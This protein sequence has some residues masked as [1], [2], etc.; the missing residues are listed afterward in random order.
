QPVII[1]FFADW[2][3]PC[4]EMEHVTYRDPQIIEASRSFIMVKVDV[5]HVRST[6]AQKLIKE[7]DVSGI[8][9]LIFLDSQ[10]DEIKTERWVGYLGPADF[11]ERLQRLALRAKPPGVPA[12]AETTRAGSAGPPRAIPVLRPVCARS[13]HSRASWPIA[14]SESSM[15]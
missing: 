2:C 7:Y 11:L 8:P 10:G 9:T 3:P 14:A 4:Q 15:S 12:A 13:R 1:D 5:T 6:Q